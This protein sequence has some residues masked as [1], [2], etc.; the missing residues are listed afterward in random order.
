MSNQVIKA[1]GIKVTSD[2]AVELLYAVQDENSKACREFVWNDDPY[3]IQRICLTEDAPFTVKEFKA[4]NADIEGNNSGKYS[5]VF[6]SLYNLLTT[7]G[8][9]EAVIL[10]EEGILVLDSVDGISGKMHK[11]KDGKQLDPEDVECYSY[12]EDVESDDELYTD[13]ADLFG[14]VED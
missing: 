4:T 12:I 1:V 2:K 8:L 5:P 13:F 9:H 3:G 11:V 14:I 6:M 10:C 7:G